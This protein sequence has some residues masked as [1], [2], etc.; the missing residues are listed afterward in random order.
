M[1]CTRREKLGVAPAPVVPVLLTLELAGSRCWWDWVC[2]GHRGRQAAALCLALLFCEHNCVAACLSLGS[3]TSDSAAL[4]FFLGA[5]GFVSP[6]APGLV[7]RRLPACST[8]TTV[9]EKGMSGC[10]APTN[11]LGQGRTLVGLGG[12]PGCAWT[13]LPQGLLLPNPVPAIWSGHLLPDP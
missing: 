13:L 5:G 2:L 8:H 9:G 10:P 3:R 12:Y 1:C 11:L 4:L 6:M 7:W